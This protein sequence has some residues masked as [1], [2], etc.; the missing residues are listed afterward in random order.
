MTIKWNTPAGKLDTIVE[1]IIKEIPL[2]AESDSGTVTYSVIAGGLPRGMRLDN[3]IIKGAPVEVKFY[4][5]YRFV[6]R[7]SDGTDIEDRTFG[8][9]VDGSDAPQWITKAGFL[10]VGQGENY[11]VLDNAYVDFQLEATDTD[12]TA[13]DRLEYYLT[14]R[15]GQL[16]PGLTLTK[17]GRI[18]GYTDPIF[19]IDNIDPTGAYDT[20][21]FD[22]A[23]LDVYQVRS[24]GYDTYFY[25]LFDFDYSEPS[26]TPRRISRFY[27]FVV[28]VTDGVHDIKRLFRIWVVTEEFLKSDNNIIQVG[29][30]LY[31]ADNDAFRRPE[32]ITESDLGRI[33]A[34]NYVT[35]YLDVYDP[36]SLSGTIAY[37]LLSTNPGT[38]RLL[39]TDQ[40]VTGRYDLSNELPVFS[41]N[42]V[43]TWN[44]QQTYKP[45]EAVTFLK[46]TPTYTATETWVCIRENSNVTPSEGQ[47]WTKQ[48]VNTNLQTFTVSDQS[49]WERI[50]PESTSTIPDGLLLDDKTGELAG[51]ISYQPAISRSY[52]FTVRAVNFPSNLGSIEYVFTGDWNSTTTYKVNQAVRYR[53]F[54][55]IA[56]YENKG[57]IPSELSGFWELGVSTSEK[58]FTLTVIGEIESSIR[59]IS[60]SNVGSIKPNQS[61][62]LFVQAEST[63][64]NGSVTYDLYSGNL[65]PGLSLLGTGTIQGKVRQFADN[66]GPGLTRFFDSTST[67]P[68]DVGFDQG[69]TTFNQR[70][71]FAV[72]ARDWTRFAENI[73]TFYIDVVTETTSTFANLYVKSFPNKQKR[74]DWYNFIADFNVFNPNEIYRNGDP[75]FG[76]QQELKILL[77]AGIESTEAAMYV[78]AMSRNH[79]RKQLRF[80]DIKTAVAKDPL[81]QEVVYEVIYIQVID[82]YEKNGSNISQ[83]ISLND[84]IESKVLVSYENIRIDSNIPLVSDSDT[85]RVFPNSIKN[86]RS[87]IKSVGSTDREFLPLWMRSIQPGSPVET[88]YVKALVLCYLKPGYS[89]KVISRIKSK[90]ETA[91]RGTW[92]VLERY[93]IGD[94]VKYQG[95]FYTSN[96]DQPSGTSP[97]P[98]TDERT[99]T[100]N[101]DFKSLD[102]TVDRYVID[103]ID[104]QIQEQ[105]LAFPQRDISNKF[106]NPAVTT[107]SRNL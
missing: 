100:K 62:Q 82:E 102:F 15:S 98:G 27:T 38:Y 85:Q 18:W 79:Y 74:L 7:A 12:L 34:N 56:L 68:F 66:N 22:I 37:F 43:G 28:T 5:T 67:D 107:E 73:K 95:S 11:F 57:V 31:R 103:I 88:G 49:L 72:K 84:G 26:E 47:Y 6:V 19:A 63:G 69:T 86:M 105:Y 29:T 64:I 52:Q 81:T 25:D 77:Y 60:D 2:S 4:T 92:S 10:N 48:F 97:T 14:P 33:R 1:R 76:V 30:N 101:F 36:P 39:N 61:S 13:G 8:I 91:T 65:P 20:A 99:W 35:V 17:D 87:R 90:I 50:T 16:P 3:G 94:T 53:G 89:E 75:N 40:I 51:K 80:G 83:V 55:Y 21:G 23:P 104:G 44:N 58:T 71:E 45:S 59:W 9:D 96:I 24:N 78:Q 106:S 41:Y 42:I 70:F 46:V 32:W 54:I 93:G